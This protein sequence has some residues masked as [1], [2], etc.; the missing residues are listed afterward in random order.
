MAEKTSFLI[1]MKRIILIIALSII[2]IIILLGILFY[3]SSS[4]SYEER[5]LVN[6][7]GRQRMLTQVM[8]KDASRLFALVQAKD[9]GNLTEDISVVDSK[10]KNTKQKISTARE[11][12]SDTL[13]K[14]NNGYIEDQNVKV[15]FNN[16]NAYIS[17]NLVNVNLLW[18]EFDQAVDTILNAQNYNDDFI[19][20]TVYINENNEQLLKYCDSILEATV[21]EAKQEALKSMFISILL[22]F[23]A[24][25]VIGES[26]LNL[27]KY[28][29]MPLNEIYKGISDLGA[30]YQKEYKPSFMTNREIK[31]I[32]GEISGA[33]HK[34][35]SI[36]SLIENINNSSSFNEVLDFIFNNFS[37]YIPYNH[38]GVAIVKENGKV[39]EATHGIT[40]GSVAGL[41]EALLNKGYEIKGSSLEKIFST[42]EA[43]II[44]DLKEYSEKNPPKEYTKIILGAGIRS[45]ITLPLNVKNR[46]IGVI[47]FSSKERNVYDQDHSKFL[48]VLANSIA[49]TFEK[50]IFVDDLLY[51]SLL[52]L[53][54]LA[55]ARDEDT[56][57]HL[58]R[59]K[60]YAR[61]IAELLYTDSNYRKEIFPAYIIDI[62][63]FSPMHDIGKV[64]IRDAILLKPGKLT[65]EEFEEM[66]MHAKFGAEVLKTAEKNIEKNGKSLF[67]LGIE[68][69]E[70]HHEKWDGSGYPSGK[71]G[72]EIP[73]SAR[74]VAVAD[75]FDALSSRRPYKEPFPFDISFGMI[76]EGRG[77]HFDPEIVRVFEQNKDK[78]FELYKSF[79]PHRG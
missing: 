12:F 9:L 46:N 71:E 16:T 47:F 13:S 54:K 26:V 35:E 59:M 75:V 77:K 28:F 51:S 74:I 58:E 66:K 31:P 43:R 48:K 56:G 37:S 52:A 72:V 67:K 73:L 42:G 68:I 20:S 70:G 32:V 21:G 3:I 24:A 6:V 44:N 65:S 76:I 15:K 23:L 34:M 4:N 36:I 69:A 1:K 29:I 57:D 78:I 7:L 53:A 33:F 25:I 14:I 62:E 5:T 39:L 27:Y 11:E 30:Y 41:P 61:L 64:G 60:K 63:R 2:S 79:L 18:E 50:N 10:I 19:K 55:E 40:D 38:I 17:S 22:V 8:A 45:S 49:I